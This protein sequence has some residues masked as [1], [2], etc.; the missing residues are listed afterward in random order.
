MIYYIFV[1]L[2][3]THGEGG[4]ERVISIE[5]PRIGYEWM[6]FKQHTY[7]AGMFILRLREL[8]RKGNVFP[9]SDMKRWSL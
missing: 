4:V 6:G 8:S 2:D 1:Y 9:I 5:H 3:S 7:R